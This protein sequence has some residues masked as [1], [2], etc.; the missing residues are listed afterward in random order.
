MYS[1]LFCDKNSIEE[2]YQFYPLF[3]E[4]LAKK[5][6]GICP[7][8]EYGTD[9]DSAIPEVY[10]L[11]DGKTEWQAIV[12]MQADE[13]NN[14]EFKTKAQNPFDY[15]INSDETTLRES[16]VPLIRLTHMLGGVPAPTVRFVG[17]MVEEDGKLPRMV[18]NS[19]IDPDE[20]R[21]YEMLSE[22]YRFYGIPPTQILV[23][24]KRMVIDDHNAV[25]NDVW[26]RQLEQSNFANRN[27]Y[28]HNC[29]FLVYDLERRGETKRVEELFEF[30][31]T[32]VLLAIN[33]L[34]S[35]VLK[36]YKLYK[37]DSAFDSK[38][39]YEVFQ[40]AADRAVG[41]KLYFEKL[42]EKELNAKISGGM[43]VPK[44]KVMVPVNLDNPPE[45]RTSINSDMF[46]MTSGS[47]KEETA[48]FNK[49]HSE[50]KRGLDTMNIWAERA[51]D[52]SAETVRDV[53]TYDKHNVKPLGR[54]QMEDF[55]T[56]LADLND[57]IYE[58]RKT[59]PN[60]SVGDKRKLDKCAKTVK[61][62]ILQR[63]TTSIAMNCFSI[64]AAILIISLIS[65]LFLTFQEDSVSKW[66]ILIAIAVGVALFGII[67]YIALSV[68]NMELKGWLAKYDEL[69][70]DA[71]ARI[72][73]NALRFSDYLSSVASY[74][75]G[76]DY[77]KVLD[78]KNAEKN[79]YWYKLQE[80][81]DTTETFIDD[82]KKWSFAFHLPVDFDSEAAHSKFD[83][84][85][86]QTPFAEPLYTFE[87]RTSYEV[88]VNE[89][90]E[91]IKSPFGFV[92]RVIIEREELFDDAE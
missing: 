2:F 37:I 70:G 15:V 46:H 26:N 5:S 27:A 7:W 4:T 10:D 19:K 11:I 31:T 71:C 18:Y 83:V 54:Y 47:H 32:V 92:K 55:R 74:M 61:E 43:G 45:T 75:R 24:S 62:K 90:G 12:V 72:H 77:I 34:D 56:S 68:Q 3:T 84:L 20:K 48:E 22:K 69:L 36:A 21:I 78:E 53:C 13:D 80:Q 89:S 8:N 38:K 58:Q 40:K 29:R 57:S 67:E 60:G 82:I 1:V 6:I 85:M 81:I 28:P 65:G 33:D 42:L 86:E 87:S 63:A 41:A 23:I 35:N 73:N 14:C 25:S 16:P 79:D 51:L 39:M 50:S 59:L 9:I 49:V 91:F 44:Y 66:A 88:N 76:K 64:G 52:R 30:W 17:E